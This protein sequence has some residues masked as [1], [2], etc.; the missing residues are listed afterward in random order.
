MARK[1][2][3]NDLNELLTEYFEKVTLPENSIF[4]VGCS[5]SEILGKWK[6]TDSSL[7]VGRTVVETVRS[8]LKP[9]HLNLAV[10]GCEH[11]N[12]ALVLERAVA[13]RHD[14]EIVSVKPAI[15]AGGGT[16]VAAYQQ[17]DDPV[18]VE[19]IVAD[20]GI[21]IG[22]TEIGMHVK[23]VQIP[24]RL[25]HRDVGEARVIG[26]SSRPKLIGGERARYTFTED[27]L[28]DIR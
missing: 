10:Q 15:H 20:G 24:V 14:F 11:I 4:V 19:H 25:A 17:F 9:R 18:E 5:T 13:E 22:G 16:Q 3:K 21:D 1:T 8:F 2:I 23:F 12:R 27:N 26:L 6:G 7:D 28:K